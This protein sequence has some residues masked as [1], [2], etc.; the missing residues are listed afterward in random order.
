MFFPGHFGVGPE[1][2]AALRMQVNEFLDRS[3]EAFARE[4]LPLPIV[5]GG[6]TPTAYESGL[7]HG[8]NEVRPGMYIFN[9]RNTAGIAAASLS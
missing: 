1:Q 6:S 9:D 3:F 7:F 4:G 5:S 8:V 2:R